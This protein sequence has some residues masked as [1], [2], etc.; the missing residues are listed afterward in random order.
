[1]Q[2]IH[3]NL[4][5]RLGVTK[6]ASCD[7]IK[8]AY[9]KL[10]LQ[11]HPD[12]NNGDP[13][14][15]ELYKKINEAYN[16]LSNE[17]E[18]AQYDTMST[19]GLPFSGM[20]GNIYTMNVDP[21]TLMNM[22]FGSN[23]GKNALDD[24]GIAMAMEGISGMNRVGK[25]GKMGGIG[26]MDGLDRMGGM[27]GMGVM[28]GLG[29]ILRRGARA[30][31]IDN[32]VGKTQIP[33]F[34][35]YEYQ[36]KPAIINVNVEI[37]ILEA[38]TGCKMPISIVRWI[39]E[40]GIKREESE[41]VYIN[42]PK[43]IDDNEIITLENKGNVISHNNKGDIK[44]KIII[45]NNSEFERNGLDLIYK[46]TISLKESLCGFSFDIKYIDGREFK[47]NNDSG[48]IIPAYFKKVISGMGMKRDDDIGNLIILFT[49][50]YPK[51]LTME[52]V[53]E[54]EKIL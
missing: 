51:I 23:D 20:Q 22:L 10:S 17:T 50:D 9:R 18:R 30:K 35:N 34:S 13:K 36:S 12:R 53:K 21:G 25:M 8:K 44:I 45:N 2:N 42:I 46:K 39:I 3:D 48:N 24:L 5:E 27:G 14:K 52:Q 11:Y 47:I 33:G 15:C 29:G 43:G 32:D 1:M 49:I 19:C 16:I 40:N 28:G 7:E 6:S 4:Y 54:L 41:T 38:F 37:N 31:N 26:G